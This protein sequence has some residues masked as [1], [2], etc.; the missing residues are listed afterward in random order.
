MAITHQR[1]DA[2]SNTQA[3][4]DFEKAAA[5]YL[6]TLGFTLSRK[7][8]APVGAGRR[9]KL[10]QFDLGSSEPAVLVECKSHRWT[11]NTGQNSPSAKMAV[12][13]EAMFYFSLVQIPARKILFVLRHINPRTRE[14]LADYYVRRHGHLVAA[15]VEIWEFDEAAHTHRIVQ[16]S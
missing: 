15:D 6:A 11:K 3:G 1:E 9:T 7:F 2:T 14:A 8:N 16:N 12:W 4:E 13:N 5:E 10:K